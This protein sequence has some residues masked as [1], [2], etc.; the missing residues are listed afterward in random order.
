MT[1]GSCVDTYVHQWT[2]D[3]DVMKEYVP[4]KWQERLDGKTQVKD[5]LSGHLFP[6]IGWY[7]AFWNEDAP[8]YERPDSGDYTD[9]ERYRSPRKI[10]EYLADQ[11]VETAI[12]GGHE[13]QFLPALLEPDYQASI[14]AAYNRLLSERWT[15]E[16]PRLKGHVVLPTKRPEAAAE[17]IRKYADDPDMVSALLFTGGTTPL[18]DR[19]H[20]PIFEA[21]EAAAMPLTVRTSGN[22]VY[23]ETAGDIPEKYATFDANLAQHHMANLISM[24]FQ[25]VFDE[26]PELDVV[27]AGEGLGWVPQT[28]WRS[29]RY[30]RNFEPDVPTSLEREPHEYVSSNCYFTTYSLG[31]LPEETM[32]TYFELV[33]VDNILYASGYPRWNA[34]TPDVLP[35][36]PDADREKVLAENARRVYGL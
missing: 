7:H 13:I 23:R 1:T 32:R 16:Y 5:V 14:A 3:L 18:G 10:D 17:E 22:N 30:Y 11:G 21:A 15:S 35:D 8:G 29:T 6:Q 31:A 36:I 2:V 24:L 26:F 27:W 34:D 20:H 12:L 9:S 4:S 33:G 19:S 25:G 28:G